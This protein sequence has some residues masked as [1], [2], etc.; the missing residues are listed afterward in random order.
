MLAIVHNLK[1]PCMI[2][3]LLINLLHT[4]CLSLL[5]K[6]YKPPSV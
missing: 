1:N 2:K 3:A 4:E 6:E 5:K